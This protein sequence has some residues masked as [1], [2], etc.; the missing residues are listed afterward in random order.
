MGYLSRSIERIGG[1]RLVLALGGFYVATAAAFPVTPVAGDRSTGD[2]LIISLLVG[3]SGLVLSYGGYRLSRTNIRPDLYHVVAGWCVRAVG[4]MV[5]ILLFISLVTGLSDPLA[6]VLILSALASVAGLG[7]GYH[8]GR[9]KTRAVDAEEHSRELERYRAIV[10]TVNDGIFV[11]DADDRFTLVNDAYCEMMGYDREELIGSPTSLVA[12]ETEEDVAAI[13][14]E[15]DRDLTAGPSETNTYETSLE[16]ASGE[17]FDA[18]WSVAPLPNSAGGAPDRVVVVRDVT[19]RN[20]RERRLERQNEQLDSFASLLA[21]ELRNPVTIGQIYSQ[22]LSREENPEAV[23]YVAEAF[24]RIEDIIDVMLLVARGRD[25]ISECSAVNLADA[26]REAWTEVDAPD[27]TLELD[28]DQTVEADAT[29]IRH[30]FRNLF[31]NAV[32]H[33]GTD[34]TVTVGTLPTGFYVADDGRGIDLDER[35]TVFE[36]GYTSA[37]SEGGMGLGL[38]FVQE[39]ATAY[40]WECSVAESTAGG[41][42]FEFEN[43]TRTPTATE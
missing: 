38:T 37:A 29:Y 30:L 31:E 3:A 2:V 20:E 32:E 12:D 41:A 42:Q 1:R 10:E 4:V 14:E 34:V 7:M 8:D 9:A 23:E 24:D 15:V 13:L 17:T 43:V 11:A 28:V 35:A 25:A 39:M 5:G 27:A 36:T 40:E 19:E 22:Q 6:N 21:H 26:A 18:E 33:G 16:T